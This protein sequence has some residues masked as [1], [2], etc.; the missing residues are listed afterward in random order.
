L[1]IIG[2]IVFPWRVEGGLGFLEEKDKKT[3]HKGRK[4][5]MSLAQK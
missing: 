5:Y 2:P 1:R 4:S 3:P